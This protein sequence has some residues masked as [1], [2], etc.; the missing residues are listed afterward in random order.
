MESRSIAGFLA[1]VTW[2][3]ITKVNDVDEGLVKYTF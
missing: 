2:E 3:E 1:N